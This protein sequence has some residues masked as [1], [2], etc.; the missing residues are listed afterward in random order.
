MPPGDRSHS[1][2]PCLQACVSLSAGLPH[3][4]TGY[5]RNWGRDTFIA[6][7]GLFIITGRHAEARYIILAFAGCL[8]HGLIPNLLDGGKN[9]RFN[10][11]DAVWWWLY[12]IQV[13]RRVTA[14]GER[15]QVW[16]GTLTSGVGETTWRLVIR[17]CRNH[18][19]TCWRACFVSF[20]DSQI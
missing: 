18:G 7:R 2:P 19:D 9:S 8:R 14:G 1:P 4:S 13:G 11:R 10:C 20:P 6:L 12:C 5:M 17:I 15:C 3:F 16:V